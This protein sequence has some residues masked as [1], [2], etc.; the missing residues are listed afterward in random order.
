MIVFVANRLADPNSGVATV[1]RELSEALAARGERVR[2]VS[3]E[4]G[5]VPPLN[6]VEVVR[7]APGRLRA[8]LQMAWTLVR[9]RPSVVAVHGFWLPA[10]VAGCAAAQ[11]RGVPV[12]LSPHGMFS[13]YSFAVKGGRKR[14]ALSL[15][16]KR[17]LTKVTA[18]HTTSEAE[19]QEIR[20]LGLR[21]P[22]HVI[23]N[24]VAVADA[25][26]PAQD[27][28]QRTLLFMSRIHP[29]KGLPL[30]L[31]ALAQLPEAMSDWR[32]VVAGPDENG[33]KAEV[34]ALAD[35]LGIA[36][37]FTGPLAGED[38]AKA[39][40]SADLFVLP[41][42]NEN[43]GIVIAEALA[44]G[45]PALTTT[46]TPWESLV[47]RRAGWWVAPE[48]DAIKAALA[49]AM[50]RPRDELAAMGNNGKAWI[51]E[52]F[53][54]DALA[55]RYAAALEETARVAPSPSNAPT[56]T[57]AERRPHA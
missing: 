54:W 32:L 13:P 3:A 18:F 25:T 45:T 1:V 40:A 49:D 47:D 33:H 39:L 36:V 37:T 52:A 10:L 50:A 34:A 20:S 57:P 43:F 48:V 46:G 2:I 30:L 28:A 27:A 7:L 14:L 53:G 44:A 51:K 31:K 4:D 23:P 38:K 41:T 11:L 35:A 5:P 16:F 29:K 8:P 22:V 6:G 56:G 24:G 42:H 19:R 15:G 21:Q 9:L 26:P 12:L 17:V 55:A